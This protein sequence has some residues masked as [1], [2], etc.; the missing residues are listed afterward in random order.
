MAP[1]I[2]ALFGKMSRP[3]P[4]PMRN[5]FAFGVMTPVYC[6]G[7]LPNPDALP[8]AFNI[9]PRETCPLALRS[10]FSLMAVCKLPS[11]WS[12]RTP[13]EP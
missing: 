13:V 8:G 10:R 6:T 5:V 12:A 9:E 3:L 2:V 1:A 4:P 11:T 7:E